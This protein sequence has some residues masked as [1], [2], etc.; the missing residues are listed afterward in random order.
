MTHQYIHTD[1]FCSM[2]AKGFDTDYAETRWQYYMN[3]NTLYELKKTKTRIC[4]QQ[5]M[6]WM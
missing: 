3:V 2:L 5:D 6:A 1:A 4:L